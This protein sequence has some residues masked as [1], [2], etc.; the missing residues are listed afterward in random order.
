M[1]KVTVIGGGLAG[2]EAAYQ[3]AKRHV[4]VRLLEM[5]PVRTTEVH[6][7]SALAELVC[8]NSL[9]SADVTNAVGLLKEEMRRLDS[10]VIRAADA[11]RVPAGSALA[12]DRVAFSRMVEETLA[13]FPDLE[14]VREEAQGIPE[15]NVIIATGP[16]TSRALEPA[17]ARLTGTEAL[18]FYDAVAPIVSAESLD[19]TR[20]YFKSRYDKGEASYL[21]APFT[22]EEFTTFYEAL[23]QAERVK[24]HLGDDMKIFEG[25]MAIEDMAARGAETLRFG[26][27]KPVG[28]RDPA[29]GITPHAVCQ[30]RK[31]NAEG[32][33]YNLVGCQTHLLWGE[34]KR[35]VHLIPGL[36]NAEI[37]RYGVM[38]R[39]TYIHSPGFLLPTY[40][41]RTRKGLYFAGQVTGV[42]GY[43]ESAS[44]GFVAGVNLARALHGQEALVFPAETALGSLARFVSTPNPAFVTMNVNFGLFPSLSPSLS[45]VSR[46]EAYAARSLALIDALAPEVNS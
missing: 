33:L 25:C 14:V 2:C 44:S 40:E 21:N 17:I 3:L 23:I 10:L 41:T 42:E 15:G 9:R 45:R 43:V 6:Q 12:V 7:T 36:E 24:P 5:R 28:L 34:Q 38:H 16:L 22:R 20:L 26:P 13:G 27:F 31:E 1:D 18:Y 29:T 39:N 46:K 37:M 19:M 4:P 8:S 35:I 11:T 32:T 30:L